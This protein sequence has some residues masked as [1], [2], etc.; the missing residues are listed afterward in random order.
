MRQKLREKLLSGKA[1]T[2]CNLLQNARYFRHGAKN[3][4]NFAISHHAAFRKNSNRCNCM[5]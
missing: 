3:S 1:S 2:V 5:A 4:L